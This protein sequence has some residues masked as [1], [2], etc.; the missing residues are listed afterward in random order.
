M[1]REYLTGPLH[2]TIPYDLHGGKTKQHVSVVANTY[3]PVPQEGIF[4][5]QVYVLERT[6]LRLGSLHFQPPLH[7]SHH[8]LGSPS[9][10]SSSPAVHPRFVGW[11]RQHRR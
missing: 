9:S 11:R 4:D 8:P 10:E 2:K 3:T 1:Q 5:G 6:N 7:R